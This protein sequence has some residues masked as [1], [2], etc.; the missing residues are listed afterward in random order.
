M[1]ISILRLWGISHVT[2]RPKL[3]IVQKQPPPSHTY[4][5]LKLAGHIGIVHLHIWSTLLI[6]CKHVSATSHSA[7]MYVS[8]ARV[9]RVCVVA[10][11]PYILLLIFACPRAHKVYRR[12]RCTRQRSRTR[13]GESFIIQVTEAQNFKRSPCHYSAA[14]PEFSSSTFFARASRRG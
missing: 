10:Y 3:H 14:L 2:P 7:R 4:S 9:G 8:L 1:Q 11:A 13:L 5:N 6:T 12:H